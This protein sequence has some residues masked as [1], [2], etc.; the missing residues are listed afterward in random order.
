MP[1]ML[2]LTHQGLARDM[3]I[4]PHIEKLYNLLEERFLKKNS[5]KQASQS[6]T[7]KPKVLQKLTQEI[8]KLKKQEQQEQQ[9]II[10]ITSFYEKQYFYLSNVLLQQGFNGHA[11]PDNMKHYP[12]L[13]DISLE[14]LRI[15]RLYHSFTEVLKLAKDNN[16]EDL[17]LKIITGLYFFG[18]SENLFLNMAYD[19]S[20]DSP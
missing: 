9:E 19:T 8:E 3:Y 16:T 14:H 18:F 11:T 20:Q 7:A 10:K 2:K 5:Y 15:Q 6:V 17:Y 12:I 13:K 4:N 1:P